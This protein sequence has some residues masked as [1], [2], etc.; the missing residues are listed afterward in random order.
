[1]A[2]LTQFPIV[3]K[4]FPIDESTL[5]WNGAGK[6]TVIGGGGGGGVTSVNGKTGA[7][8]TLAAADVGADA[9]GTA[10]SVAASASAAIALKQDRLTG[11]ADVP[12][13]D[14]ALSLR[15]RVYTAMPANSAGADGDV[16]ILSANGTAALI[17]KASGV[18]SAV[19]A[20]PASTAVAPTRMSATGLF[21]NGP[22]TYSGLTVVSGSGSIT[23]YGGIDASGAAI[24]TIPSASAGTYAIEPIAITS[25]WVVLGAGIT[26]DMLVDD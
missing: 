3:A 11:T 7:S 25:G 24:Q 9:A 13:L 17:V 26:V 2:T 22:G 10:A 20:T 21:R 19:G 15:V 1:M 12:G 23:V 14:A 8:I 5:A 18:W 16:G 6:L 4:P